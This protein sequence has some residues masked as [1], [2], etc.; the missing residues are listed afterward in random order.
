MDLKKLEKM[1]DYATVHG[2]DDLEIRMEVTLVLDQE[3]VRV[4]SVQTAPELFPAMMKG[5]TEKMDAM[6]TLRDELQETLDE[7]S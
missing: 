2:L 7:K 4:F 6:A 3:K 5:M 1:I